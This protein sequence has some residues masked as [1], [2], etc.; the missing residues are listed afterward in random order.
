MR[1]SETF[2]P[3]ILAVADCDVAKHNVIV[4]LAISAIDVRLQRL[5]SQVYEVGFQLCNRNCAPSQ[6]HVHRSSY[7]MADLV[8]LAPHHRGA[9]AVDLSF[10]LSVI[11]GHYCCVRV[12]ICQTLQ[13]LH[14][15]SE[16][17]PKEQP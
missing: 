12:S 9:L 5:K 4:G 3:K 2:L 17:F 16:L 15:K 11:I 7:R 8:L 1:G 14:S 6:V 13:L 10:A